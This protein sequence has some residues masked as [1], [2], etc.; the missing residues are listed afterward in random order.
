L[1]RNEPQ[2]DMSA[3]QNPNESKNVDKHGAKFKL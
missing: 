1:M 3:Q 2:L